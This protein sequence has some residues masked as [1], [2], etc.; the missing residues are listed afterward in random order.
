LLVSR[1]RALTVRLPE[2]LYD[3][4]QELARERSTSLNALIQEGL[5]GLIRARREAQLYEAFGLLGEDAEEASV[6]FAVAAQQEV[7]LADET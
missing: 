5:V 2:E 7:V 3:Q 1:S 4:S 6:E